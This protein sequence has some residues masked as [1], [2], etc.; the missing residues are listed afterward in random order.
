[1]TQAIAIGA[2]TPSLG[3][4]IGALGSVGDAGGSF[5]S[6]SDEH[7]RG[8]PGA[9]DGYPEGGWLNTSTSMAVLVWTGLDRGQDTVGV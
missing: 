7:C 8:R 9:R 2:Y 6:R 4:G 1:M 5:A 3:A